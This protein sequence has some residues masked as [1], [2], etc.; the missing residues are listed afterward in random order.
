MP[1]LGHSGFFLMS[2]FYLSCHISLS[3]F[4]FLALRNIQTVQGL[5]GILSK[6]QNLASVRNMACK[7]D[8]PIQATGVL[9]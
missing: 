4:Y 3:L 1:T 9:V 2:Q 5:W 8:Y 7:Q 6:T